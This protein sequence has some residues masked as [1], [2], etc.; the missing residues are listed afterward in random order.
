M[1]TNVFFNKNSSPRVQSLK[2]QPVLLTISEYYFFIPFYS[3]CLLNP[4]DTVFLKSPNHSGFRERSLFLSNKCRPEIKPRELV[5]RLQV[6]P[7]AL[8]PS[9][10]LCF[11]S[12]PN[13]AASAPVITPVFQKEEGDAAACIH[14]LLL[15]T[16][17]TP[18]DV[19][20]S[21]QGELG[22]EPE[23]WAA[24]PQLNIRGL[25]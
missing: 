3:H 1:M 18:E 15:L 17:R 14:L 19:C 20:T 11:L 4:T 21:L 16:C 12:W 8:A 2:G 9:V 10:F 22:N 7:G 23:F 5:E 6:S 25:S 13:G 24:V